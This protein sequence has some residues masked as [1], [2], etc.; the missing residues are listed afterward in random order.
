MQYSS[1]AAHGHCNRA[2]APIFE[3]RTQLADLV[4][5]RIQVG[6]AD[7]SAIA[8]RIANNE[9]PLIFAEFDDRRPRNFDVTQIVDLLRPADGAVDVRVLDT[10]DWPDAQHSHLSLLIDGIAL[11]AQDRVVAITDTGMKGHAFTFDQ[12]VEIERVDPIAR[13][14]QTSGSTDVDDTGVDADTAARCVHAVFDVGHDVFDGRHG[15]SFW[16]RVGSRSLYLHTNARCM[17]REIEDSCVMGYDTNVASD[18][19]IALLLLDTHHKPVSLDQALFAE[20]RLMHGPIRVGSLNISRLDD[21]WH[22]G[23]V[24]V[25]P[26]FRRQGHATRMLQMLEQV[27]EQPIQH[28]QEMIT[29]RGRLWAASRPGQ[30][31]VAFHELDEAA[32]LKRQEDLQHQPVPDVPKCLFWATSASGDVYDP[33]LPGLVGD[34]AEDVYV[35]AVDGLLEPVRI[36]LVEIN[37][38]EA[39][40]TSDREFVVHSAQIARLLDPLQRFQEEFNSAR[41]VKCAREQAS[42]PRLASMT[43]PAPLPSP[44]NP[45]DH[46]VHLRPEA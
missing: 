2:H 31:N 10:L 16:M 20:A 39:E 29:T 23:N 24:F 4:A 9:E 34:D 13:L 15:S 32:R 33:S 22:I 30:H 14:L 41:A 3:L 12:R 21:E 19:R 36:Q 1:H 38:I 25:V 5:T 11:P 40:A 37:P 43:D 17:H 27:V 45:V 44:L 42:L 7:I 46:R 26:K 6:L 8:G 35:N 18:L 28:D